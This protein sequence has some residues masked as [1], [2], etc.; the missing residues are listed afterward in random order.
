MKLSKLLA[1]SNGAAVKNNLV[2]NE[3][4]RYICYSVHNILV[5]EYLNQ[6]KTQKLIKEGNDQIF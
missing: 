1:C 2:W 6:E 4:Q 5:I 3:A